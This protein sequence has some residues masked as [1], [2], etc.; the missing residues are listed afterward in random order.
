MG[1]SVLDQAAPSDRE[2]ER[3]VVDIVERLAPDKGVAVT[4]QTTLIDGLGY[5]SARMIELGSALERR[6]GCKLEQTQ[7]GATTVA[8]LVAVVRAVFHSE[9]LSDST[10]IAAQDVFSSERAALDADG[11]PAA[12]ATAGDA[13]GDST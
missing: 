9:S 13:L 5:D 3:A 11:I 1:A 7:L 10:P 12:V 4:L 6:L 8:D 2:I